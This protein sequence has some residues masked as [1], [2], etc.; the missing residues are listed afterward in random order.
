MSATARLMQSFLTNH[1]ADARDIIEALPNE[2]LPDLAAAL[3]VSAM[4]GLLGTVTP[5]RGTEL[6]LALTQ[7]GQQQVIEEAPPR[8]AVMLLSGLTPTERAPLTE[9][10]TASARSELE[11]I[12]SFPADTAAR[13]MDSATDTLEP[14]MTVGQARDRLRHARIKRA[15]SLY[16]VDPQG[17]LAGRVDVQ[18]LATSKAHEPLNGLIQSVD[19]VTE[20]NA[21]KQELVDLF[22]SWGLD[23]I[24]VL[25]DEHRL[26]GVVRYAGI[27]N[28][29]QSVAVADLQKMVGASP[30]EQALSPP[31]FAVR[32]RLPW[33]HI[34]LLTAF[35]AAAVVGLFQELISQITAL[36]I[37]LPVVAGQSG[38]AGAQALAVTMRGLTLREVGTKQWYAVVRKE[39]L[40]G[41]MDGL[42]LAATCGAGVYLWSQ[43][44]GLATVIGI[45][46]ILS[47][48]AA[49]VAG[50]AVPMLLTRARQD[51]ATASS[52][53]LTTVTDVAGFF[54]FLGTATLLAPMI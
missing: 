42:A 31:F 33:L 6:F 12:L 20:M 41:L 13:L 45:A 17:R 53:I 3:E 37:L 29:A 28:A 22:T 8:I 44:L 38:N 39:T 10:L 43:S 24:P 54:S 14:G 36:A 15:R 19:A 27:V 32:K 26:M 23:S 7:Q 47:M 2:A 48:I 51:P 9:A 16:V 18:D 34:N 50:A 40:V 30:D 1:P 49:G 11:R 5:S 4:L 46:M 21:S 25:N 35:L 52:I